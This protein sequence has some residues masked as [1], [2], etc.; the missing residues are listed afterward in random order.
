MTAPNCPLFNSNS[1]TALASL[2]E[3]ATP[4]VGDSQ[5]RFCG[6]FR[7][8]R[9]DR[10][11]LPHDWCAMPIALQTSGSFRDQEVVIEEPGGRWVIGCRHFYFV[12]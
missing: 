7:L 11:L 4:T 3:A 9:T 5:E 6:S 12:A 1:F 8:G 10:A 2:D